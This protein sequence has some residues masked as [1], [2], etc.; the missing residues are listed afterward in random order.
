MF[1]KFYVTI[2]KKKKIKIKKICK[3]TDKPS[4]HENGATFGGKPHLPT[5]S[6]IVSL[7]TSMQCACSLPFLLGKIDI[8]R[9]TAID[10]LSWLRTMINVQTSQ[11]N[12]WKIIDSF[13]CESNPTELSK[14]KLTLY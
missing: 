1:K 4:Q 6:V 2:I 12:I 5:G 14:H 13:P 3:F 9:K 11:Q 10:E 8:F 7:S